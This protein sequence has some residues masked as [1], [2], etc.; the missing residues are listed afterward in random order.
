VLAY[1]WDLNELEEWTHVATAVSTPIE[2]PGT[3][4]AEQNGKAARLVHEIS[5]APGTGPDQHFAFVGHKEGFFSVDLSGLASFPYTMSTVTEIDPDPTRI[6]DAVQCPVANE[7]RLFA[8]VAGGSGVPDTLRIFQWDRST[9]VVTD[10]AVAVYDLTAPPPSQGGGG[11]MAMNPGTIGRARF[12]RTPGGT[13]G[14]GYLTAGC[15]GGMVFR[16]AWPG[17]TGPDSLNE[18]DFWISDYTD[19]MT[20]CRVFDFSAVYGSAG[21]PFKILAIKNNEAFAIVDM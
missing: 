21:N 1:R 8:A 12:H 13:G 15:P 3:P 6:S 4:G 9:G 18:G 10:P 20:D 16:F 19:H 14:E 5:T 7:D 11:L 17:P 2:Y